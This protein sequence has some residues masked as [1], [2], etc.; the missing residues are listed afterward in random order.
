MSLWAAGHNVK[1]EQVGATF[2]Q[3]A[4]HLSI[5]PVFALPTLL[6]SVHHLNPPADGHLQLAQGQMQPTKVGE[7]I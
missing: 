1:D 7:I 2:C 6:W 4:C 3:P 5:C